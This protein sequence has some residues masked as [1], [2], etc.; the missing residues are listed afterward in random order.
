MRLGGPVFGKNESPQEWT[1][2]VKTHGYTAAFCPVG[3]D[4]SDEDIQAYKE[5]AAVAGIVVAEVG[6]WSNPLSPDKQT[7][8]EAIEKCKRSLELAEKIS[9]C[10]CVNI[11]GSRGKKWDGPS[12]DDVKDDTFALIVDLV[13][14]IV[15]AVQPKHTFYT[16][17]TM[18]WMLPDSV[19][20]YVALLKAIDRSAF[21]VHFDPVNLINGPRRYFN[22]TEIINDFIKRLGPHI[23]SSHAK[24][25]LLQQKL[26]VHLDEVRPGT[27]T[28]D[29]SALLKGLSQLPGDVPLMLEHLP[30]EEEYKKGADY[31][32]SMASQAGIRL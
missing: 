7:R 8:D 22:T 1:A 29:Y 15:D 13:R 17:E 32:R 23:K 3:L 2:N 31:I 21:A 14:E 20:T 5:A 19:D 26:T 18:P 11:A 4:A 9:A 28:L 10:C 30:D 6:A 16:L 24:D 27:G 25:I 12:E